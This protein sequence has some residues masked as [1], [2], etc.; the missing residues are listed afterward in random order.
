M[1]FADFIAMNFLDP[2]FDMPQLFSGFT[3]VMAMIGYSLQIY[4]DFSGYTDIAIGLALFMGYKLPR[5]FDSPYKAIHCGDFWKRWHI[6][7][8]TW[9]KDYLYIPLGGNRNDRS[10]IYY[11]RY[12]YCWGALCIG[13]EMVTIIVV[14]LR[15]GSM[16]DYF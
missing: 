6:S 13:N 7:L 15:H 1:I 9:L 8:S 11:Y 12:Y 5:N 2:V 14:T 16:V 10:F 3:N 4:G